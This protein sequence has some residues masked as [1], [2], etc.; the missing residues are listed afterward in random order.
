MNGWMN[1]TT[2]VGVVGVVGVLDSTV[3]SVVAVVTVHIVAND[4][5]L[6]DVM[7]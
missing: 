3:V 7:G 2:A 1:V 4:I 5:G 6:V